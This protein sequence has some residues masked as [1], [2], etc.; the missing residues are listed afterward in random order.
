MLEIRKYP[1]LEIAQMLKTDKNIEMNR[2][3]FRRLKNMGVVYKPIGRGTKAVLDIKEITE[4]FKVMCI[5]DYGYDPKTD[6]NDLARE[7]CMIRRNRFYSAMNKTNKNTI[8]KNELN[9]NRISRYKVGRYDSKL[10]D[11]GVF[12]KNGTDDVYYRVNGSNVEKAS[13]DEYMASKERMNELREKGL[14][15]RTAAVQLHNE[16]EGTIRSARSMM[17]IIDFV[18]PNVSELVRLAEDHCKRH[19]L[20]LMNRDESFS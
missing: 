16:N 19:D 13:K 7:I 14:D 1:I 12:V 20:S 4:P 15:N 18:N 9:E 3:T 5:I 8:L 11:D 6:F 17:E 2:T 10:I